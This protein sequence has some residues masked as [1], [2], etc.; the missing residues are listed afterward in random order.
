MAR[1][2][3]KTPVQRNAQRNAPNNAAGKRKR[4]TTGQ[5]LAH[6]QRTLQEIETSMNQ[7]LERMNDFDRIL[8]DLDEI[9]EYMAKGRRRRSPLAKRKETPET[10][11]NGGR[12]PGGHG[13][14]NDLLSHPALQSLL[15]NRG[16]KGSSPGSLPGMFK[17]IDPAQI[18]A[19]LQNP[20]VQSMLN[21]HFP[22]LNLKGL[23]KNTADLSSIMQLL[24][25]P[26][27]Q[28]LLKKAL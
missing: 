10:G 19:L 11:E 5:R 18:L 23:A 27:V 26:M 22:G 3:K 20:A 8:S 25:N 24:Q 28:S 15:K 1:I 21:K 7:T 16:K 14:L 4:I 6:I 2:G 13:E 17:N 12:P 9:K